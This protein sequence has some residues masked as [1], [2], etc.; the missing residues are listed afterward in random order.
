MPTKK[1]KESSNE[2]FLREPKVLLWDIETSHN[3]AATWGIY[4]QN[5]Q[6]DNILKERSVICIS[7]KWLGD[8]RIY[9]AVNE[10]EETM[11]KEMH[12]VLSSADVIVHHNGDRFD[13]PMFNAR[14]ITYGINPLP[15]IPT[16]DTLKVARK[17]FRFNCNK[18]DYLGEL[19]GCGR[20][21]HT[22]NALW[23]AVLKGDK[24]ALNKMVLYNKQ[25][26]KLLENVYLKL[27]GF[28]QSHPNM[29]LLKNS[30]IAVCPN[31]GSEHIQE[32]GTRIT[33][34]RKY[35]RLQCQDCG[36]WS[37]GAL[38]K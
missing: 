19:L 16:V 15:P 17:Y 38:V 22:G 12:D 32:R 35:K 28:M 26:V 8:K 5:I 25:D 14:A 13:L 23:L 37:Q 29:G 7:Y 30:K 36:A 2:V 27:R 10:N 11:L 31:C 3:I 20:K 24:K 34:T 9:S 6:F 4:D 33:K 21:I 1:I 18:L